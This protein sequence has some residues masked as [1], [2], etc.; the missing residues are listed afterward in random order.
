MVRNKVGQN[1]TDFYQ[2][3]ENATVIFLKRIDNAGRTLYT[4]QVKFDTAAEAVE[5]F[6]TRCGD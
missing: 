3:E 2:Y 6:N 4:H 1:Y 5:F